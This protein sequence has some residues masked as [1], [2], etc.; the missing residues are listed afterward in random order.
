MKNQKKKKRGGKDLSSLPVEKGEEV[1][2][3]VEILNLEILLKQ[4][5]AGAFPGDLVVRF[6]GFHCCGQAQTLG[7]EL[8][9]SKLHGTAKK[10]K[11]K[12]EKTNLLY[13]NGVTMF[14]FG[15]SVYIILSTFMNVQNLPN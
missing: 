10:K 3:G 1:K 7:E 11:K 14:V 15:C 2:R 9:S 13:N 6:L 12:K 5:I 8:R 4:K